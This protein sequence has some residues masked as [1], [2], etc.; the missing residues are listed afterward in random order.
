[1]NTYKISFRDLRQNDQNSEMLHALE[2]GFAKYEIDYYL[3]GA[4]A[5]DAWLTGVH[6]LEPRTN[7]RDIDFGVLI[8]DNA[9][10]LALKSYLIDHEGFTQSSGNAFVLMYKD[11]MQVDLLPFGGIE[12]A[13][14]KV[15]SSGLGLTSINLQGFTEVFEE[16]L[17]IL[18]IEGK[19]QFR[20]CTM[21]GI[22]LLKIISWDDRPSIRFGDIKDIAHLLKH[23]YNIYEEEI[24]ENHNDLFG[25]DVLPH[26]QFAARVMGREMKKIAMRNQKLFDR[27]VS[28]FDREIADPNTSKMA[29][30]M[31]TSAEETIMEKMEIINQLKLGFTESS[32]ESNNTIPGNLENKSQ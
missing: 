7:T 16:E 28:I 6:G 2:R 1:M 12:E 11:R 21:P 25:N 27:I 17:P 32:M 24:W 26:D 9:T 22:A 18:D 15:S 20:F 3:V 30:L 19:H 31:L 13:D 5:R 8:D 29:E 23:F 10:Y 4:V 14:G